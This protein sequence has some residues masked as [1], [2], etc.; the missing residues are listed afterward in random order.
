MSCRRAFEVDVPAYVLD[1]RDP[2]WDEFRAHYPRCADCAAE[3]AA[4]T[5]LQTTLAERHPGPEDLLRWNDAPEA[6]APDARAT[7]ARHVERCASCRDELRALGAFAGASG[8]AS[9]ADAAGGA[10][11]AVAAATANPSDAPPAAHEHHPSAS[12]PGGRRGERHAFARRGS[13]SGADHGGAHAADDR[14]AA[15]R[16]PVARVLLHPAFAYAAL[17][18][19][20]L[21]PTVR[22][23]LDRDAGRAPFETVT[24]VASDDASDVAP[25]QVAEQAPR[26]LQDVAPAAAP[27][28]QLPPPAERR[29]EEAARKARPITDFARAQRDAGS[30]GAGAEPPAPLDDARVDRTAPRLIRQ[31]PARPEAPPAGASAPALPAD[32]ARAAAPL[33]AG[34]SIRAAESA[35]TAPASAAR[36]A[37]PG[38]SDEHASEAR[39]G[40]AHGGSAFR[41]LPAASDGTRDLVVTLP[42][43]LA[44]AAQLEV[45]IVDATGGRELR[46]RIERVPHAAADVRVALPV[47]FTAR[48][49]R[50][51]IHAD[52]VGPLLQGSVAP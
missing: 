45:R 46:Q 12:R 14:P 18:L 47:G 37:A 51:E 41:L 49:L 50:V 39:A 40:D 23:A 19:V 21:L 44:D 48:V 2:A 4:W 3:V 52:G 42:P 38:A 8:S 20:L 31:A 9:Q 28:Q 32:S 43:S 24:G 15:R 35:G 30:G 5:A 36:A 29:G 33:A 25:P 7:I 1:P 26:A 22:A 34:G 13:V 27:A 17:V 11:P 10:F 6:L 16:G